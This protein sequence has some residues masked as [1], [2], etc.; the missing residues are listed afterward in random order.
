MKICGHNVEVG[1]YVEVEYTTGKRLKGGILRG[2]ITKLWDKEGDDYPI[3]PGK[4][5]QI[6]D[7]W[8][9]HDVDKILKH[10]P[11]EE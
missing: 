10:I 8:C 11:R 6:N 2:T 9:F 1:D 4:Q 3:A 5:A 7:G